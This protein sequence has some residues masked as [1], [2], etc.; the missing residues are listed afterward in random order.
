MIDSM[1]EFL[2]HA[3]QLEA[4]AAAGYEVLAARMRG[5]GNDEVA[6]LFAKLGEFSQLHLAETEARY[7]DATGEAP[8]LD[9]AGFRWPDGDSPENPASLPADAE[10]RTREAIQM[11]LGL[12]RQACDF[13]SAVANQTRDAAVQELAQ[14]FTEEESEHV[15]HLERWLARHDAGGR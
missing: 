2:A 12:E 9:P 7:R 13:Y 5:L 14:A 1:R 4:N 3:V 6:A 10:T 11:A 15:S 8:V